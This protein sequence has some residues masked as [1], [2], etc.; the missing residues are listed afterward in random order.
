MSSSSGPAHRQ[1]RRE[2][3]SSTNNE[4]DHQS[5]NRDANLTQTRSST[6]TQ[7][8]GSRSSSTEV[9]AEP[10]AQFSSWISNHKKN[11]LQAMELASVTPVVMLAIP[12][13]MIRLNEELKIMKLRRKIPFLI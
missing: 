3:A 9:R 4:S 7:R 11:L 5:Y 8:E 10:H 12:Q 1:V 13:R 6:T 2:S